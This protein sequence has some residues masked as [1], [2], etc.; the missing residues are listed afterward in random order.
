VRHAVHEQVCDGRSDDL[1]RV[2]TGI[3]KWVD[4]RQGA[5]L[6]EPTLPRGFS[7]RKFHEQKVAA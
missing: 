7:P 5:S 2:F 1:E 6:N 4:M 3:S